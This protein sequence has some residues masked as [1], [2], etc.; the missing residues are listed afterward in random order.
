[1]KLFIGEKICFVTL[2]YF[3]QEKTCI[4]MLAFPS[5][6]VFTL[7]IVVLFLFVFFLNLFYLLQIHHDY[8]L[9]LFSICYNFIM[10]IF[11]FVVGVG[12]V[13]HVSFRI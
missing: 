12:L 7:G 9:D 2:K 5:Y 4:V 8:V 3:T 13:I 1:M 10:I 6:V 11:R